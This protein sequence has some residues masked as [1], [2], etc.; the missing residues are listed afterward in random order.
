LHLVGFAVAVILISGLLAGPAASGAPV[1]RFDPVRI[2]DVTDRA[3]A[4]S[5]SGTAGGAAGLF[6]RQGYLVPDQAGYEREKGLGRGSG[7]TI[8]TSTS[9]NGLDIISDPGGPPSIGRNW[10]GA[11]DSGGS[12]P[13]ATGAIGPTRYIEL[14]NQRFAIYDR[15]HDA[16]LTTGTLKTMTTAPTNFVTDPQVIWDPGT[17]RFYFVVLDFWGLMG[18]VDNGLYV[19]FSKTGSPTNGT[20]DWCR[21][22]ISWGT[23]LPDY[24]KLGDSS[25]FVMAG[26]NMFTHAGAFVGAGVTWMS[27][28]PAGTTCP[29]SSTFKVG[30]S[31][32]MLLDDGVTS[33]WTPVAV[34]QTDNSSTG[35]VLA[36]D[37]VASG[38]TSNFVDV[39]AVTRDG[40]GNAVFSSPT[41]H[42]LGASFTA[43]PS[44]PQ[45][46]TTAVL[47]TLDGRLT[48]AVSGTDPFRGHLGIWTQHTIAG[49][50]GAMVEWYEIDP[51]SSGY[52]RTGTVQDGTLD[53]FNG[54]ISPDRKVVGTT[55]MF[56]SAF[57]IGFDTS[58]ASDDVRIQMVSGYGDYV[59]SP[60]VEV[61][62]SPGYNQDATCGFAEG[63]RWGD[64]AGATPDPAS[65][66]YS[67]HGQ[68]WLSNQWNIASTD[69]TAPDWRTE[70]W[71]TQPV[72]FVTMT[73]PAL[74]YQKA[75]SFGVGWAFGN[76]AVAADVRYRAAPWNAGFGALTPWQS[77]TATTSATYPG[78]AGNTYCFSAQSYDELLDTSL[79]AWGWSGEHCTA[80]P[81]DDRAVTRDSGWSRKTGSGFYK[82]TYTSS[83]T[84]GATLTLSGVAA[85]RIAV[86]VEKCS[87]CGSMRV[88][89][90]TTLLGT[91]SLHASST[92]KK[93][94]IQVANFG[95]VRTGTL[96]IRDASGLVV[97]DG[98]AIRRV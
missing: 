38:G 94:Y 73:S 59:L 77:A 40:S 34:N 60:F 7:G 70:N 97:V 54:A 45:S 51:V 65:N 75:T 83:S 33:A 41:K 13:D 72:P 58:S 30:A 22:F 35:Y 71:S 92:Q 24:P 90:G 79:R 17:N 32:P 3:S 91:W 27:K 62:A 67:N 63:C 23:L 42:T 68:V 29:S 82:G 12:P 14:I 1:R 31:D 26:S 10:A 55:R 87:S 88:Y 25:A 21:Y 6:R 47:D 61:K 44:A 4:S 39:Y 15:T 56:G 81:L 57:V 50:A 28:P 78:A 98:V 5:A 43:P 16:A 96:R 89:W 93:V 8:D 85:K 11:T 52:W 2:Q 95:S 64:Y 48:Q 18:G 36:T 37:N 74:I 80:V 84:A 76:G 69:A 53:V 49:G 19:G 86:M 20:T 46:G 9:T 66:Q